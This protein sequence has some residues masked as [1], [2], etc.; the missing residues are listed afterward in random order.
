MKTI[1]AGTDFTSSSTNACR[2]AA[3]L[4]EKL[5]CKLILFNLFYEP[6]I[7]SNIG[8]FGISYEN[9]KKRSEK[10]INKLISELKL[11][12]PKINISQFVK[13]GSFSDELKDFSSAHQVEVAVM[14][15]KTKDKI[16]KFIYGSHGVDIAGKIEA[17]VII[18]PERYKNHKLSEILLAVDN[19][20]KLKKS[21]LRGFER[22]VKLTNSNVDLLYVRTPNELFI[23]VLQ[24]IKINNVKKEVDIVKSKNINDGINRYRKK[25]SADLIAIVSKQ[26]SIIYNMF[27]ESHTKKIAFD[28]KV[29]VM[30]IHE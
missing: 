16:S 10:K 20:E 23:P 11:S 21:T 17:P 28:A 4:A 14:G 29:P 2:Y 12:F 24:S 1:I 9:E 19:S 25:K 3:F 13:S 8:L 22:L 15:L 26:H 6:M 7:H 30:A 5:N 27:S 18:V